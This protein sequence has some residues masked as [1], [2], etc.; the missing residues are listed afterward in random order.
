MM[1]SW[2]FLAGAVVGDAAGTYALKRSHG[3]RRP[4]PVAL[5]VVAYL[6]A[7]VLF[8]FALQGIAVSVADAVFA[9]AA[10]VLIT[11]MGVAF[12]GERL[13]ARKVL[14]LGLV[15][16]GVVALRLQGA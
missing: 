14:G 8:S 1:L 7:I 6:L 5:S 16:L 12:L 15:V 4:W 13:G 9:A 3:M 11:V 2:L 10:T